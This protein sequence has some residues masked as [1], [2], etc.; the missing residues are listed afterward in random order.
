[1]LTATL[2]RQDVPVTIDAVGTVQAHTVDLQ[3]IGLTIVGHHH[4]HLQSAPR[5]RAGQQ[6]VLHLLATNAVAVVLTRDHGQV[7]QANKA[8]LAH[9]ADGTQ[10]VFITTPARRAGPWARCPVNAASD[11]RLEA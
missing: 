5:Q 10:K 8:D 2:G 1:M 3:A 7:V 11:A 9:V 6:G 4:G